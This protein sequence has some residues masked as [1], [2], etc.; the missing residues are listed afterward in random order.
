M[1]FSFDFFQKLKPREVPPPAGKPVTIVDIDE[2]SLAEIGQWPWSR[3]VLSKMTYNLTKM[4]AALIAYDVVFAEPDPMNPSL[5]ASSLKGIDDET[6]S[7]L[8]L[9]PD[10]DRNFAK[11]IKKSTVEL[12]Q[13]GFWEKRDADDKA[14]PPIKKSITINYLNDV[15][16]M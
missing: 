6:K 15:C 1:W 14:N 11:A 7:K 9:L 8:S 2:N 16:I 12:G 5:I 10:N 13:A 4:G 3:D